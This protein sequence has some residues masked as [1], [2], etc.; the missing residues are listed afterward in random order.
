MTSWKVPRIWDGGRCFILG[1][2]PC[3][4][5]EKL[6]LIHNERV[7][8][9]NNAYEL[10]DWVD[11][12][13]FGDARWYTDWDNREK[14]LDF[15]GLKVCCCDQ[16]LY[17]VRP[18]IKVIHRGKPEGIDKR[19][20]YISWNSNSGFSAINLAVHFGVKTIVLLG[21]AM[22]EDKNGKH[23][24]HDHHLVKG[25]NPPDPYAKFLG[26]AGAIQRDA[27]EM[28]I[29]IINSTMISRIPEDVFPRIP[30]EEVLQ[31]A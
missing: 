16:L 8:G 19:P 15:A 31:L 2:S 23:N 24:W 9:V 12:C 1:G 22:Q 6:E 5:N 14:L 25:H 17:P 18:G 11:V 4:L 13:Y 3:L 21:F 26:C 20:D 28:E 27:E 10:G 30:L 7:I 29:K